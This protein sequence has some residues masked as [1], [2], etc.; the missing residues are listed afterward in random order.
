MPRQ[1]EQRAGGLE[2]SGAVAANAENLST[3]PVAGTPRGS[4][5]CGDGLRRVA[6]CRGLR[7]GNRH[8]VVPAR[9]KAPIK[10]AAEEDDGVL[11][12]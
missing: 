2:G 5:G 4:S 8:H 1:R 12:F 9:Q 10:A 7:G 11:L 3:R 6:R